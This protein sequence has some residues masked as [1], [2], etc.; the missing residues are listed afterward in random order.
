MSSP[1]RSADCRAADSIIIA[2]SASSS[3]Y[4]DVAAPRMAFAKSTM[5][6]MTAAP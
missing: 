1:R 3:V 2:I 6:D 5:C 4:S